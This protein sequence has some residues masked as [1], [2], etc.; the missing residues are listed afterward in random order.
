M[1]QSRNHELDIYYS[2]VYICITRSNW[3]VK[4]WIDS[5]VVYKTDIKTLNTDKLFWIIDSQI[6]VVKFWWVKLRTNH[7]LL[8][9]LN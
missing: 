7:F 8:L 2:E 3:I 9:N 4:E 6:T 1:I 5:T